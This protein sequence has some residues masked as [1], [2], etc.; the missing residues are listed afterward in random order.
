MKLGAFYTFA[1]KERTNRRKKITFSKVGNKGKLAA[2]WCLIELI[3]QSKSVLKE[4]NG[5]T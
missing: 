3:R 4:L 5:L 2:F 1:I